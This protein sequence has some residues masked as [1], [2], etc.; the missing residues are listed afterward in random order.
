MIFRKESEVSTFP[1][2]VSK[3]SR[4]AAITTITAKLRVRRDEVIAFFLPTASGRSKFAR[5]DT[6]TRAELHHLQD[7]YRN[8][9]LDDAAAATLSKGWAVPE[10]DLGRAPKNGERDWGSTAQSILLYC[11]DRIGHGSLAADVYTVDPGG[12]DIS[13]VVVK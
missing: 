2:K 12:S 13:V 8:G 1:K 9:V 3:E 10:S 7:C 11:K 4:V 5:L 6:V